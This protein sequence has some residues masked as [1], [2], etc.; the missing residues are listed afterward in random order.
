MVLYNWGEGGRGDGAGCGQG[1]C[2]NASFEEGS[3]AVYRAAEGNGS[4]GLKCGGYL[5]TDAAVSLAA[6]GQ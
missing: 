1:Q 6:L 3:N 5:G 2:G 4:Q